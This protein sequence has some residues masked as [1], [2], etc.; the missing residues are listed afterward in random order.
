MKGVQCLNPQEMDCSNL[1]NI[2]KEKEAK[3][4][5]QRILPKSSLQL[6]L[7]QALGKSQVNSNFEEDFENLRRAHERTIKEIA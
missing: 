5:Y 3:D 2:A 1:V 7:Q 6:K 4:Y